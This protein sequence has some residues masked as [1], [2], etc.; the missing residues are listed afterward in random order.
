MVTKWAKKALLEVIPPRFCVT[1]RRASFWSR[2]KN[3]KSR[4]WD[5]WAENTEDTGPGS[6]D[7]FSEQ[8]ENHGHRSE[9][10]PYS[11]N[12]VENQGF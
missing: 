6:R 1:F 5:G 2:P 8:V 4:L 11:T 12:R 9:L 10:D 3:S 7:N